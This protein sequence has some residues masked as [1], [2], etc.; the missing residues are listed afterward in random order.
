MLNM[1][2][3]YYMFI[4]FVRTCNTIQ[5]GYKYLI[6]QIQ[7][8]SNIGKC[9]QVDTT[10]TVHPS[11]STDK[12]P[13]HSNSKSMQHPKAHAW[14]RSTHWAEP[15]W[16]QRKK[17]D[18]PSYQK[19]EWLKN[20]NKWGKIGISTNELGTRGNFLIIKQAEG[21]LSVFAKSRVR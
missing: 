4:G 5:L 9:L 6:S 19:F 13:R 15:Y 17:F 11:K 2:S 16:V 21:M 14:I 3:G 18:S 10:T 1:Y 7:S 20:R 12:V 8:V